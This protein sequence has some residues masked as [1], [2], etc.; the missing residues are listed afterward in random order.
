VCVYKALI[1]LGQTNWCDTRAERGADG[2]KGKAN[3]VYPNSTIDNTNEDK[4]KY[5]K[6]N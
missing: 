6:R 4:G 2:E 3:N 1:Q 5:H